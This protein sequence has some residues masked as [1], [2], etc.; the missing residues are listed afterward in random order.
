M[1]FD[2]QNFINP[3]DK[4][5]K[6]LDIRNLNNYL[7]QIDLSIIATPS[8]LHFKYSKIFLEKNIDVLV[9]KPAVLQ[10]KHAEILAKLCNKKK[11]RCWVAFQNRYNLA[12]SKLKKDVLN[13]RIGKVNLV[14]SSLFW[15]RDEAY[16]KVNW[17][18]NYKT[19]GG[20][21]ANQAIHLLD[22]LV[23]IFGPIKNFD[24]IAGFN[25]NKLRAEDL[26]LL[27]F[28]HNNGVLSSLKATT[29]ANKDYRVSM[30]VL[31]SKNR[32]IIKGISLNTYHYFK[33]KK[34]F[35]DKKNS[36]KFILNGKENAIGTGHIKILNEF[37]TKKN[38]QKI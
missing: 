25:K 4:S 9:E 11:V 27:N 31:G 8:H 10:T 30:D 17:R 36:E 29:R 21:L 38:L 13:K 15:F 34:F 12:V 20:V 23:Y 7:N 6:F 18:G 2:T 26:I 14:D 32:I 33:D 19:D 35:T 1:V 3:K 24:S 37:I 28:E 22:A 5:I 16:Y